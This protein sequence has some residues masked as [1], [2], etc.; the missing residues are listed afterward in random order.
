MGAISQFS[1]GALAREY[2]RRKGWSLCRRNILVEGDSD[3]RYFGL[4]DR[5]YYARHKQRLLGVDLGCFSAGTGNEGGVDGVVRELASL[6]QIIDNDRD[7]NSK[8]L[9]R[10]VG[11]LDDDAAGRTCARALENTWR[12]REGRDF[13][14]LRRAWPMR[15]SEPT[16]LAQHLASDRSDLYT[17]L[18]DLLAPSLIDA[19]VV[20]R[21]EA[22]GRLKVGEGNE[23]HYNL[24]DGI[25]G[26][27]W[28]FT[29]DYAMLDDVSR[30][31]GCLKA[32]RFYMGLPPDGVD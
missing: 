1:P 23:R 19:F 28:L 8:A 30:L 13:F 26:P 3:V 21:P 29:K 17:E 25:K 14:L 9:Y 18:E 12:Y 20:D 32:M 2:C 16:V 7:A 24:S 15:S 4:V 27:L 31:V 10:V 22:L 5:L 6:R 11:L